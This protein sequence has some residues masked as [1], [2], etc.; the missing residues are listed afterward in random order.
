MGSEKSNVIR[1]LQAMGIDTKVL[2]KLL[3]YITRREHKVYN[4]GYTKG[5]ANDGKSIN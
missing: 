1:D 3:S 2:P 5:R 4:E